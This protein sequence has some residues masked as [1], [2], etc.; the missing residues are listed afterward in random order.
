V[1][2]RIETF[3][4]DRGGRLSAEKTVLTPISQGF[5]V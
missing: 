5:D 2:P 4:A 3:L 1:L